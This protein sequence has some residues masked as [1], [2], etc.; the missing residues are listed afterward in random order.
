MTIFLYFVY[1]NII[2]FQYYITSKIPYKINEILFRYCS[3][4]HQ[5]MRNYTYL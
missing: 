3:I 2:L 5:L 4:D 1:F